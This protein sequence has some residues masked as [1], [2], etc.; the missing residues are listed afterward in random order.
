LSTKRI[1]FLCTGN[2]YRSRFAEVLFNSIA[3]QS[4]LAWQASS[5]ALAIERGYRNVGPM[6]ATALSTLEALGIVADAAC[7]RLPVQAA[8]HDF[9]QAALVIALLQEE[10]QPLILERFPAWAERVEYWQIIDAPGVLPHLERAVKELV[11]RLKSS[12]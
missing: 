7:A 12:G 4:G 9:E 6:A 2:Y 11:E 3:T 1:L 5:R 10:H 8:L